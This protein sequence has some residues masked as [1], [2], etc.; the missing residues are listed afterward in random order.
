M[1]CTVQGFSWPKPRRLGGIADPQGIAQARKLRPTPI[2]SS[3]CGRTAASSVTWR[4]TRARTLTET[5]DMASV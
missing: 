4:R 2:S 1:P 5:A 3:V